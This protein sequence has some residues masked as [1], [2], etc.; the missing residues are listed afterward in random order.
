[1][2]QPG[3]VEAVVYTAGVETGRYV[4]ETADQAVEMDVTVD[5]NE[6]RADDR[7][8]A[9]VGIALRDAQGRLNPNVDR[10][11]GV[12][13]EGA[14]ILQGIGSGNPATEENFFDDAYTTW[15][16]HALAAIRPTGS[17]EI[18]VTVTAEGCK[19]VAVT[20]IAK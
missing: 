8:L 14:G 12:T 6:I 16:G 3:T 2:Y 17:G 10:K 18:I 7:D 13:V 11:I 15:F 4:V 19:P 9:Y 20:I 5:R 1:M